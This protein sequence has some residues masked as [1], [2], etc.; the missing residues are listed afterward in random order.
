MF[1]CFVT[2]VLSRFGSPFSRWLARAASWRDLQKLVLKGLGAAPGESAKT[3]LQD[4]LFRVC[5]VVESAKKGYLS[6]QEPQP[7]R[8]P[9]VDKALKLCRL[10]EPPHVKLLMEW[11]EE[12]KR[13]LLRDVAEEQVDIADSVRE[14]QLLH[15]QAP[16]CN[17]SDCF[18]LYTKE[19]QLAPENAWRCPYCKKL[20]QGMVKLSLWTL[21][22]ILILHLK[23]FRQVGE[24]RIKLANMVNFPLNSLDMT[25]HVVRRSQ[26]TWTLLS[27]GSPWRRP[28]GLGG[29]PEDYR[30]DLYAVCNHHGSL[31]AGHYTAHCKNSLD[32]QWYSFDDSSVEPVP[33]ESVCARSAYIL[34]YQRRS[35]IPTWSASSSL[36]GST[37]S[38][39]SEHWV[40]RIPGF[41]R[42]PSL[43]SKASTNGT[44]LPSPH[45]SPIASQDPL[46]PNDEDG[47]FASR[48]FVR[49]VQNA[50]EIPT[51]LLAP[52]NQL[53]VGAAST[54]G[55]ITPIPCPRQSKEP[56]AAVRPQ[57]RASE[58][59]SPTVT[60][61][62]TPKHREQKD[63]VTE[64]RATS[65]IRA[66]KEA[67]GCSGGGT[68][69]GSGADSK[70]M[71][72]R[73][74]R[75]T[76]DTRGR[77]ST[78][79]E[80]AIPPRSSTARTKRPAS[81]AGTDIRSSRISHA[82]QPNIRSSS[83]TPVAAPRRSCTK[84]EPHTS[85]TLPRVKEAQLTQKRTLPTPS[86]RS[87][88]DK[89][90]KKPVAGS[91][92]RPKPEPR[93]STKKQSSFVA[94]RQLGKWME[95]R[96]KQPQSST[97]SN[98]SKPVESANK[99]VK[100]ESGTKRSDG[101]RLT[102]IKSLWRDSKRVSESRTTPQTASRTPSG[103]KETPQP[104][105][106]RTRLPAGD[107]GKGL[108]V[109][110]GK[111]GSTKQDLRQRQMTLGK[112]ACNSESV[113]RVK[114]ESIRGGLQREKDR[115]TSIGPG[116]PGRRKNTVPESSL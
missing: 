58:T 114:H 42:R 28:Q 14:Q 24:R 46:P 33:E 97:G 95:S 19:E 66:G 61:V 85:S 1:V 41:E 23:R 71:P 12:G 25:P 51:N 70:V 107:A 45:D 79:S 84:T 47:G 57:S 104:G 82:P 9:V 3:Q 31:Q 73:G 6:Y 39:L 37:C 76:T 86:Q 27:Q 5:V 16:S 59:R 96:D 18:H 43:T 112:T 69:V 92:A 78:S 21:P 68:T 54:N 116:W 20:Q 29:D 108:V 35:S 13:R 80:D 44:S 38:F 30:Y 32:G 48:P 72:R 115:R 65:R 11:D 83:A 98:G 2:Y 109:D 81:A 100:E 90:M 74:W 88:V 113:E 56:T 89:T 52:S 17:L 101:G 36:A 94:P 8:L 105:P 15:Q 22:D 103:R 49:G 40:N 64:P 10:G 67:R 99:P 62:S 53:S 102:L 75:T 111:G 26:S 110:K 77:S 60:A 55:S 50:E 91:T 87:Q 93:A 63:R 7:L 4:P 106:R 34:F